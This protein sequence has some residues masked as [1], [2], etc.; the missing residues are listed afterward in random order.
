MLAHMLFQY[1]DDGAHLMG[2]VPFPMK[3]YGVA[4]DFHGRG[5][6]PSVAFPAARRTA[7]ALV[8]KIECYAKLASSSET[9][10]RH[11][12]GLYS[13]PSKAW[14]ED[15]PMRRMIRVARK[16]RADAVAAERARETRDRNEQREARFTRQMSNR[17]RR[18]E[19][20]VSNTGRQMA[21]IAVT[22]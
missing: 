17:A 13:L 15:A 21:I 4:H 6:D 20:R 22:A 9:I 14:A 18:A 1:N 3:S 10:Q 11:F 16:L 12:D 2:A 19:A 5:V 8:D 7:D